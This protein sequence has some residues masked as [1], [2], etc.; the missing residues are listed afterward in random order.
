MSGT[1]DPRRDRASGLRHRV[2]WATA[3]VPL[4]TPRG[5]ASF[6]APQGNHTSESSEQVGEVGVVSCGSL[7]GGCGDRQQPPEP[8]IQVITKLLSMETL[9]ARITNLISGHEAA[10]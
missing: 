2:R 8:G 5:R 4:L 6:F 10:L 1:S 7:R 3:T 9:T